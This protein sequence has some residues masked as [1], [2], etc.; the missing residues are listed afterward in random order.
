VTSQADLEA[1]E[2]HMQTAQRWFTEGWTGHLGMASSIF[3]A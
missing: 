3:S 1:S 2:H